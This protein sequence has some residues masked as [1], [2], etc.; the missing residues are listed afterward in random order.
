M[1]DFKNLNFE[2]WEF[3]NSNIG[4]ELAIDNAF[5]EFSI[6]FS[7]TIL[8]WNAIDRL[9]DCLQK[10]TFHHPCCKNLHCGD[11][12]LCEPMNWHEPHNAM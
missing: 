5:M 3:H 1:K 6:G 8:A 12:R 10:G 9:N 11:I 7:K 4:I 2:L